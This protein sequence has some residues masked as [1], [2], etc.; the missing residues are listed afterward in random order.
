MR[1]LFD[2]QAFDLQTHG[3]VSHCMAELYQNL[4]K[5]VQ[6]LLG[7]LESDNV[8]MQQQGINRMN[9]YYETFLGIKKFRGKRKIFTP[10]F[11]FC[12]GYDYWRNR[13][14]GLSIKMLKEGNYDVF[15]PTFFDDYFLPYLNGKPFVLTIHDMIPELYP[16]Y[17]GKDDFQIKKK[18]K[19]APLAAH[20][21]V[22][23]E[24]TKNDVIRLLGVP[25]DKISVI[26]HGCSGFID[27][28]WNCEP[29]LVKESYLLFVGSRNGYKNFEY[30]VKSCVPILNKF[31]NI[32]VICTGNTFDDNE[33]SLFKKLG[34]DTCFKNIFL[35]S[36]IEL[37]N[38]YHFALA[39]I[40]PSQYEGFGLPIL[41]SYQADGLLIL[42]ET[43]CFP[44]IA[45]EAAI[46]FS[47][48][49]ENDLQNVLD[50]VINKMSTE[51]REEQL[52][53]QRKRLKKFSWIQSAH[54]L[55][56]IYY[57]IN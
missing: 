39:F 36:E 5:N 4:P 16:Q 18:K 53:K 12:N 55:A 52:L 11:Q 44:E 1:V 26:Y 8:Y 17:Y 45:G 23:S 40:F 10:Y 48:N 19:L 41:E 42:N 7:V 33:K 14:Q 27:I 13:N 49:K 15:H 38:L 31:P 3:G 2:Y 20:I 24:Q 54:Q 35:K 37:A 47:E 22:P 46:Y 57:S 56:S 30:F 21:V 32:K 34:V 25:K 29:R 50:Y 43:S 9:Y 28:D 6:P 51:E